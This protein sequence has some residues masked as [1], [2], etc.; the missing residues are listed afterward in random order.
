MHSTDYKRHNTCL[1]KHKYEICKFKH[2]MVCRLGDKAWVGMKTWYILP[3]TIITCSMPFYANF[4]HRIMLQN[5][6][7]TDSN[8]LYQ[9]NMEVYILRKYLHHIFIHEIKMW[10]GVFYMF[11]LYSSVI[12]KKLVIYV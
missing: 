2:T 1:L 4:S 9:N 5:H 10:S 8:N 7:N 6:C 12:F 3:P 11:K